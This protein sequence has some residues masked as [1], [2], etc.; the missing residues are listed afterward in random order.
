MIYDLRGN[1]ISL[2][3]PVVFT[4]GQGSL[5]IGRVSYISSNQLKPGFI[6]VET[7]TYRYDRLGGQRIPIFKEIKLKLSGHWVR[8]AD[9]TPLCDRVMLLEQT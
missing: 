5:R 8:N 1:Q 7:P 9:G 6:K 4:A 3:C 2:N